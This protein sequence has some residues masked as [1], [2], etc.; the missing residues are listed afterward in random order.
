MRNAG[1]G[2]MQIQ[3]RKDGTAISDINGY[4][5]AVIYSRASVMWMGALAA[6]NTLDFFVPNNGTIHTGYGSCN[7]WLI[8]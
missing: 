6:T 1:T 8:G 7:V 4:I 5:H 2:A 3:I